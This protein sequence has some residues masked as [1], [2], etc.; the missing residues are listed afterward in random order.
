MN[1]VERSNLAKIITAT[2]MYFQRQITTEVVSMMV[3]DLEDLPF[4]KVARAYET[5]RRDPKTQ[6]FPIPAKIRGLIK[7]TPDPEAEG[8]EIVDRVVIAIT[9]FGYSQFQAA[10]AFIGPI[11][12]RIV[13]AHGGWTALCESNFIHNPAMIAQARSRATD[14]IKYGDS[15]RSES[16]QIEAPQETP[17]LESKKFEALKAFEKHQAE[18]PL[19]IEVPS[20]EERARMIREMLE[21]ANN[22]EE[23]T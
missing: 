2:A 5:I 6:A 21:R 10:M 8:R 18:K 11:G 22:K 7:P 1:S 17:Q 12:K 16:T 15:F 23:R 9:K 13:N 20:D 14:M 19:D 4:E 3:S